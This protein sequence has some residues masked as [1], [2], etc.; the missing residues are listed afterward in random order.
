MCGRYGVKLKFED[1]AKLLRAEPI[2]SLEDT[3]WGPDLNIAP[4]D[5]APVIVP[6]PAGPRL[7][8]FRWGLVPFWATD[9][10]VGAR[11][12]NARSDTI[13]EKPAFR[14]PIQK[15]RVLVPA[16]GWY[17][18]THPVPEPGK[19]KKD[20]PKPTPHWFQRRDPQPL[21]FAGLSSTWKDKKTGERR[22]TFCIITTDANADTSAIHDRMPAILEPDQQAIW[23]DATT[24]LDTLT[25]MLAPYRGA[26]TH[27]VVSNEV[28]DVKADGPRLI[29]PIE[30]IE[31][32][33]P[34]GP[35]EPIGADRPA[36][37][38]LL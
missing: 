29:E 27:H 38:T 4:T 36:Q 5:L 17:E 33:G 2:D 9:P 3:G 22:E 6:T 21:V 37:Q 24:P 16:S 30:P 8:L 32:I 14:E 1:L 18:W 13:L 15:R 26:L 19:K 23:L 28:N 12:I 31:P 7:A 25:A 35:M 10:R 11:M 20:L 34:I